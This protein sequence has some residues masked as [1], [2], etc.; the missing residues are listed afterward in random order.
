M[1]DGKKS[2]GYAAGRDAL[3]QKRMAIG[4]LRKEMREI[5]A[6]IEPQEV[7]DYGF[8]TLDG[9]KKL[10]DFFGDKTDLIVIHNMGGGCMYCTLWADGFNG[11]FDHLADRAGFVVTSP[12][13]PDAQKKIADGRGWRFPMASTTG[14]EFAQE[15]GYFQDD[16]GVTPG[17][18]AFQL[19][20]G[21]IL[22][23]S[24]T[25]FGPGDDFA[26]VWHLFELFPEGANGWGP[27]RK[28]DA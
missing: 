7:R 22:R 17:V 20:D 19:R 3:N 28:Y 4:A 23:V 24:D 27:K 18:S 1:S 9:P 11:V 26:G 14:P 10:S 8:E 2:S 25:P 15:M 5:Q 12:D 13:A 6:Q 16:F 21:K